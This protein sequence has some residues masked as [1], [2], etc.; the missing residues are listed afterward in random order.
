MGL[1]RVFGESGFIFQSLDLMIMS[2]EV[3]APRLLLL[4]VRYFQWTAS[5]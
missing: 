2:Q 3:I 5:S 4:Y 1:P